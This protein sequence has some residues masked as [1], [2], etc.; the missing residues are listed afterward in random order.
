MRI[1]DWS[2]DVCSSDLAADVAWTDPHP[3]RHASDVEARVAQMYRDVGLDRPQPRRLHAGLFPHWLIVRGLGDSSD[4]VANMTGG[5]WSRGARGSID[6]YEPHVAHSR[7]TG[8]PVASTGPAPHR[9]PV[10][11]RVQR[12]QS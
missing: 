9:P 3:R 6:D 8:Q 2:S 11:P 7:E 5:E 10:R 1:S 4:Q 12:A